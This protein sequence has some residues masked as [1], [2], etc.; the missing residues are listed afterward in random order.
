MTKEKG[1]ESNFLFTYMNGSNDEGLLPTRLP[2]MRPDV[3]SFLS[4]T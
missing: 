1:Q 4:F 2:D 3:P